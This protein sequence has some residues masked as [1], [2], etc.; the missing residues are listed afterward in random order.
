MR[1]ARVLAVGLCSMLL[2][3]SALAQATAAPKPAAVKE[4]EVLKFVPAGSMGVFVLNN[5]QATTTNLDKFLKDV[6]ADSVSKMLNSMGGSLNFLL[7]NLQ[8]DDGFRPEGGFAVALLDPQ[9]F[10]VDL[11]KM[12]P[13][14]D[15]DYDGDDDDDDQPQQI[16]FAVYIP[17]S[18][19]ESLFGAYDV[20]KPKG[21]KYQQ[22]TLPFGPLFA[23]ELKGYVVLS[24][25]P[26]VL[27]A[28]AAKTLKSI[29]TT[30]SKEQAAA[31]VE[32]DLAIF[33]D[34]RVAGPVLDKFFQFQQ[35][36]T[37]QMSGHAVGPAGIA[38]KL[39]EMMSNYQRE[40]IEQVE[41]LLLGGKFVK[42]GLVLEEW[43]TF[44]KTKSSA[45]ALGEVKPL[46]KDNLNRLPAANYVFAS[47]FVCATG[48]ATAKARD[49]FLSSI[50]GSDEL[51]EISDADKMK[52]MNIAE[53][54][55]AQISR[56]QF[57]VGATAD[58]KGPFAATLV[59][60][61]K[62]TA[63]VIT[64]MKDT[65]KLINKLIVDLSGE[66]DLGSML[67]YKA[68]AAKSGE[69]GVDEIA[70]KFPEDS[71]PADAEEQMRKFLSDTKLRLL[72]S[73]PDKTTVVITL[74]G[75]TKHM[76]EAIKTAGKGGG[77]DIT[78]AAV[79]GLKYMP[80]DRNSIAA[81]HVGNIMNMVRNVSEDESVPALK[82][83]AP[84]LF[85]GAATG[86]QYRGAVF[87]SSA[88]IKDIVDLASTATAGRGRMM[89]D[90][91]DDNDY[92]FD[93]DDDD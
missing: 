80:A 16:P 59:L 13:N 37:V 90:D 63:Q 70:V 5:V 71:I 74:G 79:N 21:S 20:D 36:M 29:S 60:Q 42:E 77:V 41:G 4:S 1:Y 31:V 10:G 44:N 55:A 54:F 18:S 75:S 11:M 86:N 68:N 81:L 3:S 72:L 50:L 46:G 33:L 62:D 76:T 26:K 23:L 39:T 34:M 7:T 24:P 45:K 61:V 91:E 87:V 48:P 88:M 43:V 84:I 83:D 57:G 51:S 69:V 82:T 66:E 52:V 85:A 89:I 40:A 17:A 32:N 58:G 28:V 12:L 65:V 15:M 49:E 53:K 47:D 35:A 93:E 25:M 30:M 9:Q 2:V 67:V 64:A 78:K 14:M 27:D 92:E 38:F 56:G 6:G 22:V 73:A 8:M 19:M